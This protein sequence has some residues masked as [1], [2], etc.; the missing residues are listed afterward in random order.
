M[1]KAIAICRCATCGKEFEQSAVKRNRREAD[2]WEEWAVSYYDECSEC[3][4]KRKERQREE[5]NQKAAE[6][7]TEAGLPKLTGSDKQVAWAESIRMGFYQVTA[8]EMERA[9]GKTAWTKRIS[10]QR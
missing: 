1:A 4:Q 5:E 7:A 2:K 3:Y 8:A 10:S 6:L 9:Q